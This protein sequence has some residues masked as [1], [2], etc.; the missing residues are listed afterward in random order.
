MSPAAQSW[1]QRFDGRRLYYLQAYC[2]AYDD[3]R[4][5]DAILFEVLFSNSR[6]VVEH[7]QCP[8]PGITS[9]TARHS[10]LDRTGKSLEIWAIIPHGFKSPLNE[11]C[12]RPDTARSAVLA[13]VLT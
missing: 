3:H 1:H 5:E 8:S 10:C 6:T 4:V 9:W 2:A 11:G 12:S 7:S 13:I